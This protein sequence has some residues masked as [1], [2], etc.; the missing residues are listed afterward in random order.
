M[1]W[2]PR[3]KRVFKIDTE[4]CEERGGRVRVIACIEDP[5]VF[6]KVLD[7]IEHRANSPPT[8]ALSN[9]RAAPGTLTGSILNSTP[10]QGSSDGRAIVRPHS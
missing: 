5:V 1:T 4:T 9:P 3:L 8:A 7:H 6:R 10:T 2:T